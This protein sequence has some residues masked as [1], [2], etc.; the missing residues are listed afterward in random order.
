MK[1]DKCLKEDTSAD[2]FNLNPHCLSTFA[3]TGL[4]LSPQEMVKSKPSGPQEEW[5]DGCLLGLQGTLVGI[6][7]KEPSSSWYSMSVLP[8]LP[9]K[10]FYL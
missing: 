5:F 4:N 2:P 1:Y 3:F 10:S 8:L 9:C 6:A 7:M